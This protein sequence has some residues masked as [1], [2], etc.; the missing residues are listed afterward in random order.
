MSMG[1]QYKGEQLRRHCTLW[2][3]SLREVT[4]VKANDSLMDCHRTDR[5][6]SSNYYGRFW[7]N[8]VLFFSLFSRIRESWS[9]FWSLLDAACGF[10]WNQK[11]FRR[12]FGSCFIA[13]TE[14][15]LWVRSG[16]FCRHKCMQDQEMLT[17]SGNGS[18]VWPQLSVTL[19]FG[20]FSFLLHGLEERLNCNANH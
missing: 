13:L 17:L 7:F 1:E 14:V 15:G 18:P 19:Q 10:L 8:D 4:A 2:C 16:G 5:Q 11:A 9:G 3:V 20:A 12:W 6:M